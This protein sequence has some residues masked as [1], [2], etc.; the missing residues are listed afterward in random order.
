[1]INVGHEFVIDKKNLGQYGADFLIAL[2]AAG[3]P[4]VMVALWFM[5]VLPGGPSWE[6]SILAAGFAGPTSAGILFSM[7]EA[8]GLK[9]TW[10]FKKARILAIFD[11]LDIILLM[12]PVKALITG[13]KWEVGVILA[14]VI[15]LVVFSYKR[16][17]AYLIP[18]GWKWT[19]FYAIIVT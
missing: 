9:S 11:D 15:V 16:L 3:F 6:K 19:M 14:V 7:L 2:T 5:F 12:I 13:F 10:L 1:M 18:L 4:W 17:H 8:A